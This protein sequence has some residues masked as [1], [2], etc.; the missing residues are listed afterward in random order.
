L[1]NNATTQLDG[2]VLEVMLP[3]LTS[4][5]ANAASNHSFGVQI[6]QHVKEARTHMASLLGC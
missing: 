3:F 4:A 2:R 1:D 5:Y 6:N